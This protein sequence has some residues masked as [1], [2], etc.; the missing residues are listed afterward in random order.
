MIWLIVFSIAVS[1]NDGLTK[2]LAVGCYKFN[3]VVVRLPSPNNDTYLVY[4]GDYEATRATTKLR[5]GIPEF[6]DV[7]ELNLGNVTAAFN[8]GKHTLLFT[9]SEYMNDWDVCVD[10]SSICDKNLVPQVKRNAFDGFIFGVLQDGGMLHFTHFVSPASYTFISVHT[11]GTVERKN[12][13]F[14]NAMPT[15]YARENETHVRVFFTHMNGVHRL[16]DYPFTPSK[17][18]D[19]KSNAPWYECPQRMCQDATLDAAASGPG[20]G[21]TLYRGPYSWKVSHTPGQPLSEPDVTNMSAI[22]AAFRFGQTLYT[23]RDHHLVIRDTKTEVNLD[24][25]IVDAFRGIEGRVDAAFVN[26]SVV[27]I[28]QENIVTSYDFKPYTVMKP[29]SPRRYINDMWQE[30]P[31]SPD[32]AAMYL[33]HAYFFKN[34]FYYKLSNNGSVYANVI[35]G[36]FFNCDDAFYSDMTVR[37][38]FFKNLKEFQEYR[39]RF[40]PP[41]DVAT[42][43]VPTSTTLKPQT[44]EQMPTDDP[45]AS[46]QPVKPESSAVTAFIAIATIIALLAVLLAI[47]N[48]S[49]TEEKPLKQLQSSAKAPSLSIS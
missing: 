10:R 43:A 36:H 19:Y 16:K 49:S 5:N 31:S 37:L 11:N 33:D 21:Y 44:T 34:G 42:G 17:D 38:D 47:V 18:V 6:K 3:S 41:V 40:R 46:L 45:K 30:L 22:D 39:K 32:A 29:N 14:Y 24:E 8:D 12:V 48:F 20:E 7:T 27:H 15:G 2:E 1:F 23:F 26:Q 4:S 9:A 28:I 25:R 13:N 35:Q